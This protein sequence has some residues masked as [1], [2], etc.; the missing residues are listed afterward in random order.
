MKTEVRN[1]ILE[2]EQLAKEIMLAQQEIIDFLDVCEDGED[3]DRT[4]LEALLAARTD[5]WKQLIDLLP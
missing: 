2:L 5:L 4:D 1:L 3:S